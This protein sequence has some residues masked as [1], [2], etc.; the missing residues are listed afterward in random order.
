MSLH[1]YIDIASCSLLIAGCVH[2]A[3]KAGTLRKG[4]Y[5]FISYELYRIG[6]LGVATGAAF[7]V[8]GMLPSASGTL[9]EYRPS[10]SASLVLAGLA[11]VFAGRLVRTIFGG[12]GCLLRR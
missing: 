1:Q 12:R 3:D 8:L 6:H 11:T 7:M 2:I 4:W 10:L 5:R 9:I